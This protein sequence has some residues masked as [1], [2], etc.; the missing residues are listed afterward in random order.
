MNNPLVL[1]LGEIL[2]DLLAEQSDRP[3]DRVTSWKAYTG[4][5]PAN[6]ACASVKLGTPSAF[7]GRVGR[8]PV[9]DRS[10]KL[11]NR[12]GVNISA[13]QHDPIAPTRQVYVTRSS[14]GE[15]HFAGFGALATTD[16]ADTNL[17]A[18]DI[19]TSLFENA[20]FLVT[21][22]LG[23]AYPNSRGAIE[24][25]V[26]LARE[27]GVKIFLDINWRPVFWENPDSAPS[28]VREILQ[29]AD[30][31]KCSDEEAEWL[32]GTDDPAEISRQFPNLRGIL[33]TAGERG[34]RYRLGE[35]GGTAAAF[36]VT[37]V[38]TTGAG[39]GFSAGFLHRCCQFG[40]EVFHSADIARKAVIYASAVGALVTIGPGAIDPQ[41]SDR[42]VREF[43][44]ER[45]ESIGK[46]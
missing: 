20:R 26:S 28:I 5:A 45:G 29:K 7:I 44:R 12:L 31:V 3:L 35:N 40:E 4:G 34:C 16:F 9:G 41:P 33:V 13:V 39:D 14:G 43:L 1:C 15:R 25:A 42:Q 24:R 21:G 19:P 6:V 32:F 36:R 2:E 27:H 23:L 22:T 17:N 8:D 38:D 11:L 18:G 46:F 10:L 30:L 37:T